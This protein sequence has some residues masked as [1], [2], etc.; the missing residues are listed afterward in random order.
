MSVNKI[1]NTAFNLFLA[2]LLVTVISCKQEDKMKYKNPNIDI[3]ER[4]DD[5]LSRMTLEEK[6]W[7]MFMMAG[8]LSDGKERYKYGI[9][10]FKE[11]LKVVADI[12]DALKNVHESGIVH[13][14]VRSPNVLI[15][16]GGEDGSTKDSNHR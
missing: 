14:D 16:E 2:A 4:V 3:E 15:K 7:Q 1:R 6:F 8:D 9:F 11:K 12:G 13:V 10:G 5:L